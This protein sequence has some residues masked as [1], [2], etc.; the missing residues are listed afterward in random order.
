M[1]KEDSYAK[2]KSAESDIPGFRKYLIVWNAGAELL[3]NI[4]GMLGHL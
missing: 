2:M 1:Q 4:A 3:T